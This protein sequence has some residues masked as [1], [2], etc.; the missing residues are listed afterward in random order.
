MTDKEQMSRGDALARVAVLEAE[1]AELRKRVSVPEGL[2]E[3]AIVMRGLS[4]CEA[5]EITSDD[6]E[7]W[8]E[9]EAG[10]DGS[11]LFSI[12]EYAGKCADVLEAMLAAAPAPVERL[13]TDGGRNQRFEGLFEGETP[14][15]RNARLAS[16]APV[17]R[18]EQEAVSYYERAHGEK[19]PT[20]G[21]NLGERIAHVGGRTNAAGYMEFG[22]VM[23][24]SALI[25]HV[26][27]D[28]PAPQPA[29]TAAQDVEGLVDRIVPRIDAGGPNPI[30]PDVHC[31]EWTLH[32]ERER[33]HAEFADALA[34]FHRE[35]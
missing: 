32:R 6:A 33:I 23:A 10:R 1:L 27:R 21:M 7:I 19:S 5:E 14:D 9:D 30:N 31:C 12:T 29:P 26:L 16:A 22:S 17:E 18:V 3:C 8:L 15:Q 34:N 24:V 2:R 35:G 28:S 11:Y 4:L 13:A 20:H 25:D